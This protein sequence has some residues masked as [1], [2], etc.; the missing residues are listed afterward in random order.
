[1]VFIYYECMKCG[2]RYYP[3]KKRCV[4]GSTKFRRVEV[5]NAEGE[6]ET[7]TTILVPPHG[8]DPPIKIVIAK[9]EGMRVLGRYEGDREPYIGMRVKADVVDDK[10]VFTPLS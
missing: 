1:M 2:R 3:P 7:Y 5:D 8:F 9:V 6:I 4:C 10:I